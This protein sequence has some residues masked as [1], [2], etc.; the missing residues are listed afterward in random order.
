MDEKTSKRIA[1]LSQK[2]VK[3][4]L[5][6]TDLK[7]VPI[8]ERNKKKTLSETVTKADKTYTISTAYD[9]NGETVT[10]PPNVTLQFKDGGS[11]SNGT[12]IGRNTI[13]HADRKVFSKLSVQGT[14][15]CPGNVGWFAS[16]CEVVSNQYGIYVGQRIDETDALQYALDS[17][18]RELHFPTKPFYITAPLLLSREKRLVL[19][20][21][22]MKLSMEQTGVGMMNNTIIFSDKDITLLSVAV[23]ESYQNAVTIEGGSF[24]VSLCKNFTQ[25]CIEVHADEAGQRIWGLTI[26]TSVKGAYGSTTGCGIC[27]NHIENRQLTTDLAYITCVRINSRISNFGIGIR[28]MNYRQTEYHNWCTDLRIDGYISNCPCAIDTNVEDAD[29]RA[30]LQAGYYYDSRKNEQPLIRYTGPF[31]ATVACPIYD[32]QTPGNVSAPDGS[33]VETRYSNQYA[34]EIT[35]PEAVI[36]EYGTF[37]SFHLV[38]DR[39]GKYP[40]KGTIPD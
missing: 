19:H 7:P 28:A 40:V 29:L 3:K 10:L 38:S 33:T 25:N 20:G 6:L 14:F 4:E 16:G 32:L 13:I 17:S 23:S 18:F 1:A 24:D 21:S 22:D 15:D 37:H 31:R 12:L 36:T 2:A 11:I 8:A 26:N 30:T 39:S 35:R 5:V 9:L 27:I 34:I